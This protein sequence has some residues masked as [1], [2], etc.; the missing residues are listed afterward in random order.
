MRFANEK[1]CE[2]NPPRTLFV[3]EGTCTLEARDD[4]V[5]RFTRGRE[6]AFGQVNQRGIHEVQVLVEIGLVFVDVEEPGQELLLA[7]GGFQPGFRPLALAL[8]E[9]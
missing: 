1:G 8:D 5:E 6:L 9:C 3:G 4:L 2:G 7:A